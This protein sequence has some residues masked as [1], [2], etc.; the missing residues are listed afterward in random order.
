MNGVHFNYMNTA[1]HGAHYRKESAADKK[2]TEK[3]EMAEEGMEKAGNVA[4]G[5]ESKSRGRARC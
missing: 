5:V 2:G 3:T 1:L 4:Y